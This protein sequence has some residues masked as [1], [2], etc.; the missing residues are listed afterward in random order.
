MLVGDEFGKIQHPW[1]SSSTMTLSS[2]GRLRKLFE[3]PYT[4]KA[5]IR[6]LQIIK[7]DMHCECSGGEEDPAIRIGSLPTPGAKLE[8]LPAKECSVSEEAP[9]NS[10]ANS[11]GPKRSPLLKKTP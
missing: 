2:F 9:M 1:R 6:P 3:V 10:D 11:V 7:A 8:G 5:G 4:P